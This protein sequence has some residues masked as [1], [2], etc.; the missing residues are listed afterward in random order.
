MKFFSTNFFSKRLRGWIRFAYIS[1]CAW[2]V[3][4]AVL[5]AGLEGA[6]RAV[7][8]IIVAVALVL[9]GVVYRMARFLVE[10]NW[11]LLE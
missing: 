4:L 9:P 7:N 6:G 1:L 3:L 10:K 5:V 2:V 11:Y 8:Y